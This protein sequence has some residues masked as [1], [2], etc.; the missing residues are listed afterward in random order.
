[1]AR[2]HSVPV[3]WAKPVGA[4]LVAWGFTP[5]NGHWAIIDSKYGVGCTVGGKHTGCK[6]YMPDDAAKI[7]VNVLVY[8]TMP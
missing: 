3:E 1:M 2:S 5:I 4:A 7:A 6:G 8:S